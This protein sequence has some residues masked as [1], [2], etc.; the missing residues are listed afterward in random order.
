MT[1]INNKYQKTN[2]TAEEA[3]DCLRKVL[4]TSEKNRQAWKDEKEQMESM[5]ELIT[6][7]ARDTIQHK[8]DEIE[9]LTRV[10]SLLEQQIDLFIGSRQG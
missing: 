8:E 2:R 10:K 5:I 4:G 9:R 7:G 6:V 3:V 1:L